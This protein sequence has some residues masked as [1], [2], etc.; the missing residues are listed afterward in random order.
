MLSFN[1]H[2]VFMTTRIHTG[3]RSHYVMDI[4]SC[5]GFNW[6]VCHYWQLGDVLLYICATRFTSCRFANSVSWWNY[7]SRCDF[8]VPGNGDLANMDINFTVRS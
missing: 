5:Y 7:C 2:N 1:D 3:A 6:F 4:V 8:L